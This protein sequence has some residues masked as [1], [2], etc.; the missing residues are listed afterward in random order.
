MIPYVVTSRRH[1][2][3]NLLL[4]ELYYYYKQKNNK[5]LERTLIYCYK[6]LQYLAPRFAKFEDTLTI[7]TTTKKKKENEIV[8]LSTKKWNP[9]NKV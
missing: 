1:C 5:N 6:I 8:L 9:H 7:Y 2:R 3:T 4:F